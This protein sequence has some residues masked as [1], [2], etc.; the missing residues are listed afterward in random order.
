MEVVGGTR[1]AKGAVFFMSLMYYLFLC[2]KDFFMSGRRLSVLREP[3]LEITGDNNRQGEKMTGHGPRG[4]Y[5]LLFHKT[6]SLDQN[7]EVPSCQ[8]LH[9]PLG[10]PCRGKLSFSC[11]RYNT[12]ES[13]Q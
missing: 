12:F 4:L 7:N 9:S 1:E 2:I 13:Y 5:A 11:P 8:R 3:D 10:I 6:P